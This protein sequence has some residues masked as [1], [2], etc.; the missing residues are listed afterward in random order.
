MKSLDFSTRA[1]IVIESEYPN[2]TFSE[3]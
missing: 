1:E 3:F 2:K